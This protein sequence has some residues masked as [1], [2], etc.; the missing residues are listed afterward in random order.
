MTGNGLSERRRARGLLDAIHVLIFLSRGYNMHGLTFLY[1]C[2]TVLKETRAINDSLSSARRI[3]LRPRRQYQTLRSK[4]SLPL[5]LLFLPPASSYPAEWPPLFSKCSVTSVCFSVLQVGFLAWNSPFL[6]PPV[7]SLL[8]ECPGSAAVLSWAGKQT[9]CSPLQY[10]TS[11]CGS[12]PVL[13]FLFGCIQNN[14]FT[15]VI[16]HL[17]APTKP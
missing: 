17:S 3:I 9:N 16:T 2:D 13:Y 4:S 10:S 8:M 7:V 5:Q 1:V 15:C 6:S 12:I 11:R 14:L